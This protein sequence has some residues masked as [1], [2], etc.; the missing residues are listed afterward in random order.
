MKNSNTLEKSKGVVIFATN[1][2][3]ID[4]K[5]IAEHNAELIKHYL[6]LPVTIIENSQEQNTRYNIDS[7]KFE[8]WY[9]LGRYQAYKHSPYDTTILLDAD[10]FIL[11]QNLLKI[12]DTVIDYKIVR[13]NKYIDNTPSD[14]LGKYS[15]PSLWATVVV[16]EK[17]PKA[18][19]LFDLVAKVER[20]YA[21]YQRLYNITAKNFRNDFAFTI[22]DV[23]LNGYSQ[24]SSNYIPWP[25]LSVNTPVDS[26]EL[27]GNKI[28]IRS[29]QKAYVL[30]KQ[31]LHVMSKSWLAS[32]QCGQFIKD[33]LDASV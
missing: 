23:I 15:L 7:N 29:Q 2:D 1:T 30:P 12:L 25:M 14:T 28:V 3:S 24:D 20:N 8:P 19:M 5:T 11:D 18:K 26:I 27:A 13:H 4:Y 9:N 33:V 10:Y 32:E 31:S 21:Y 6:K 17:S 16:F 22:A